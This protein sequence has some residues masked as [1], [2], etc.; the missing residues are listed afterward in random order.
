[1][2]GEQPSFSFMEE[3]F[4][5]SESVH[6]ARSVVN[7]SVEYFKSLLPEVILFLQS[8]WT[9][10][11]PH[12]LGSLKIQN[13]RK[14]AEIK[15]FFIRVVEDEVAKFERLYGTDERLKCCIEELIHAMD[16]ITTSRLRYSTSGERYAPYEIRCLTIDEFESV[17]AKWQQTTHFYD[18][19]MI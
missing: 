18:Y 19:D 4:P 12:A 17:E 11:E 14:L 16:E 13:M 9:E 15:S 10:S 8:W 6:K 7:K 5:Q 2:P 1:M 3:K